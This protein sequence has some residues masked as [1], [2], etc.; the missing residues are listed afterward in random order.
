[1]FRRSRV[2]PRSQELVFL[3]PDDDLGTIRSKLES[4]SAEEVYLVIP[5][6][7]PVL[8]S[9]L[10]FRILARI[11]NE[12]SSETILVTGDPMR[13]RM[14]EHEGFR[15]KRS[16]R[17]LSHL[18]LAPDQKPP[19]LVLPD[20]VPSVPGLLAVGTG[21]A[22]TALAFVLF[23]PTMR[24]SLVPQTTEINRE[25]TI[26][27][28]PTV[29]TANAQAGLLPGEFLNVPRQEVA[30]KLDVPA[31][32][33]IGREKARGEI[34]VTNTRGEPVL[35]QRGT[36]VMTDD[37]NAG[38]KF[39]LDQELR[40]LPRQPGR[41][42][43]TAVDAGTGANLPAG[44]ISQFDGFDADGLQVGNP[45]ATAGGTDRQ[46]RVVTQEDRDKLGARLRERARTMSLQN[47]KTR[48]GAERSV[49]EQSV[50]V[51]EEAL[52]F[53]QEP[54]A[55]AD[56]L[57]GRVAFTASGTA[58]SNGAFNELVGRMLAASAGPGQ[59]L[60]G[61][62]KLDP[63]SVARVDGQKATLRTRASGVAMPEIDAGGL[64]SALRGKSPQEA[65]ALVNRLQGLAQ[66]PR[67]ELS[68]SWA[69]RVYRVEVAVQGPK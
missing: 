67:V 27:V 5:R 48:T 52:Q 38:P 4:S 59:R 7:S 51:R 21:I 28:D 8:R 19:L 24:I 57:T 9:P 47:L 42:G 50:V 25:V 45:R 34:Q 66:P 56:Q 31:D 55:E 44:V 36:R 18:M 6:R 30:D 63:P 22:L 39:V 26:T 49:V 35:L 54:G 61:P 16:L 3:D 15:T 29:Q 68:H 64:A 23:L 14:A 17:T 2:A 37:G 11:A 53:D 40:L 65:Q 10:D 20:W 69:P 32:R 13:R 43:V 1:M 41:V 60:G 33:V 58:F 62:P 12:V 46:A